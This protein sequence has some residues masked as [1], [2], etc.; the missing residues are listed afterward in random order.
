MSD[1]VHVT[2]SKEGSTF[3]LSNRRYFFT[4]MVVISNLSTYGD[5]VSK[6]IDKDDFISV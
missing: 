6:H 1:I 4:H 5:L 2:K 3:M